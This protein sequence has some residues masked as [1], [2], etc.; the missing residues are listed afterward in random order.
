ME[1]RDARGLIGQKSSAL[2]TGGPLSAALY[3]SENC[4]HEN[5][6]AP[7]P[8][9][10]AAK[11][12][13]DRFIAS[14]RTLDL[15][16]AGLALDLP[17][18]PEGSVTSAAAKE[19]QQVLA[20]RLLNGCSPSA[21]I[22]QLHSSPEATRPA[23][24]RSPSPLSEPSLR[25]AFQA[26]KRLRTSSCMHRRHVPST[27]TRILDA[28][29]LH[30]NFYLQLLDWG[31]CNLI[32]VGLDETAYLYAPET[33]SVTEILSAPPQCY[34][35]SIGFDVSGTALA[36]GTSCGLVTVVDVG[37][38]NSVRPPLCVGHGRVTSLAWCSNVE[39]TLGHEDGA[40]THHDM[41]IRNG[42]IVAVLQRHRGEV[43]GLKWSSDA[44]P[45][46]ASGAN[47]HLL[48]IYDARA[49]STPKLQLDAHKAAV[50]AVAW[51]PWRRNQLA[52]G[53]GS[54]DRFIRCWDTGSA[55][56]ALHA[57]DTGSQVS[58]LQW[59]PLQKELVSSHGYSQNSVRVWRW[60][61][62]L[63]VAELTGHRG[64]VLHLTMSP[65]GSTAVSAAADETLRFWRLS[66]PGDGGGHGRAPPDQR[67]GLSIGCP[68]L[69]Q[70]SIR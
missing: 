25:E 12:L 24:G 7:R 61:Q 38:E 1:D 57:V 69:Q 45:Q 59:C 55:E 20:H 5:C 27:P 22:L 40:I 16:R 6:Q 67:Q 28:P 50:K 21:N 65:D 43:C 60:P 33:G 10:G 49:L 34:I 23:Q 39:L 30:D 14:R 13:G 15:D 29:G 53:G 31:A 36:V 62:L 63:P 8:L 4:R 68:R 52:S 48:R 54:A 41:R 35:S 44:T 26:N 37:S 46:L 66:S 19:Y 11:T 47:D 70:S 18:G 58:G 56:P 3:L 32:A 64:R 17:L 51:C 42:G 9:R 2:P